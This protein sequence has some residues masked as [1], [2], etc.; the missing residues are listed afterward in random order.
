MNAKET[1]PTCRAPFCREKFLKEFMKKFKDYFN[2]WYEPETEAIAEFELLDDIIIHSVIDYYT[3]WDEQKE[4][5]IE[6]RNE[7]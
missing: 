2:V 4:D 5:F 3:Y 6:M 7:M 1:A